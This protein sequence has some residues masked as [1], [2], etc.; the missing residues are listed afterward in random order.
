MIPETIIEDD[1]IIHVNTL[2]NTNTWHDDDVVITSKR[3]HFD[4]ITSNDVVLT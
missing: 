2:H 3:R 1:A 4:V